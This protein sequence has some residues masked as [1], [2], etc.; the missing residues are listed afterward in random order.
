MIDFGL[1]ILDFGLFEWRVENGEW[2][3]ENL[4]NG[5]DILCVFTS[6]ESYFH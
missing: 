3:F 2:K 4:A 6:I 5:D 1:L